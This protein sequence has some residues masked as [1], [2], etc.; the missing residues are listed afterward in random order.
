M[1]R[2]YGYVERGPSQNEVMMTTIKPAFVPLVGDTFCFFGLGFRAPSAG[3]MELISS[4]SFFF[5]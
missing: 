2:H 4:D 1:L 3:W 5:G